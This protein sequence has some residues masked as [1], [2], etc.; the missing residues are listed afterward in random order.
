MHVQMGLEMPLQSY[1]LIQ[2]ME[3]VI[4]AMHEVCVHQ[5]DNKGEENTQ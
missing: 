4:T 2:I 5:R 1:Q 3:R